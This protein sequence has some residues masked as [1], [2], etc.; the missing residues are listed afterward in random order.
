MGS[1]AT[2]FLGSLVLGE[3]KDDIDPGLIWIFRPSDK[4]TE[5][6]DRRN[7]RQLAKYVEEDFIDEYDESNPF[8][9]VEYRCTAAAAK[10]RL[11]LKGF[12]FDVAEADFERELE[13]SVRHYE[14]YIRDRYLPS[15]SH[16]FEEKLRVLRTLT[17][18]SWLEGLARIK[19]ERLKRDSLDGLPGSD[20]QL[21][22][23]RYMLESSWGFYGFPGAD[24]RHVV[25]IALEA[26]TPQEPLIYDLSGLVAGG[27]VA[28]TDDLVKIAE[29]LMN[30]DFVL[31]QRVIVLTEGDTDRRFLERSLRLLYPHLV[32]YFHFFDFAGRRVGGGAGE[33]AN[34][35]RAFAAADVRHRILALFDND[36]AARAAISNLDPDSLPS[37]IAVRRYPSSHLARDYPTLGPSGRAQMDVNGLAGSLE[38]YL[39]Q[40]VLR[41]D[42]GMFSPV[43]WT[44]YDRR[45]GAYQGAILDKQRVLDRFSEKLAICEARPD[46][47]SHYD[48]EGIEAIIDT[49]RSAFHRT[50]AQAILS[51][52]I[53]E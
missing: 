44:G 39:G 51:G 11:D 53:Y 50:D 24:P 12:T 14:G 47:I 31:S 23:L 7:R 25:R 8:I 32:E 40:D 1:Y 52:A 34:L 36:T 37:N 29:H 6:I 26:A 43:Q 21:P 49:M 18:C 22:L 42:E 9:S 35:L 45:L 28:E 3:T 4:R 30:E 38:L 19:E 17:V 13:A 2:L 16:I 20:S 27:W 10:D 46:Q 48:W 15:I 41:D 5:R 33:L